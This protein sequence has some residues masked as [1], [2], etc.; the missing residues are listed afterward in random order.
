MGYERVGKT[1]LCKALRG[2]AV[3]AAEPSTDGVAV[4][5][6]TFALPSQPAPRAVLRVSVWDFAGQRVYYLTHQFFLS[7]RATYLLLWKWA[8]DRGD[9]PSQ[10]ERQLFFWLRSIEAQAPS[11]TVFV[12]GTHCRGC[13]AEEQALMEEARRRLETAF[14]GLQLRFHLVDSCA[15]VGVAALRTALLEQAESA[16]IA[17]LPAQWLELRDRV[18]ADAA[19]DVPLVSLADFQ[20]EIADFPKVQEALKFWHDL[21]SLL[22]FGE[23]EQLRK[24]VVLQPQWLADA[25]RCV[26]TQ[27]EMTRRI[28]DCGGRVRRSQVLEMFSAVTSSD[29]FRFLLVELLVQFQIVHSVGT[30]II[31]PYLLPQPAASERSHPMMVGGDA[32]ARR[33]DVRLQFVPRGLI[34]RVLCGVLKLEQTAWTQIKHLCAVGADVCRTSDSSDVCVKLQLVH[35]AG[36]GGGDCE[37]ASCAPGCI[38]L[39]ASGHPYQERDALL[40]EVL[41]IICEMVVT[42][43]PGLVRLAGED[44]FPVDLAASAAETRADDRSRFGF[45]EDHPSRLLVV[46]SLRGEIP[47]ALSLAKLERAYREGRE[48]GDGWPTVAELLRQPRDGDREATAVWLCD[49]D[50]RFSEDVIPAA[51]AA[52]A[53]TQWCAGDSKGGYFDIPLEVCQKLEAAFLAKEEH[54]EAQAG[55]WA[56]VFDLQKMVQ[57]NTTTGK[58]RPLLR[59]SKDTVVEMML[60]KERDYKQLLEHAATQ[61]AQQVRV[62]KAEAER[63]NQQLNDTQTAAARHIAEV[64]VAEAKRR[65]ADAEAAQKVADERVRQVKAE[66]EAKRT[67]EVAEARAKAVHEVSAA[68]QDVK[69]ANQQLKDAQTAAARQIAEVKVAE[70]KRRKADAEAAQKVAD[71]RVRQVREEAVAALQAP[72]AVTRTSLAPSCGAWTSIQARVQESLPQ[73]VVTAVEEIENT[74][75]LLDFDRQKD[76]VAGKPLNAARGGTTENRA[77][78]RLAFHAMAG[79]PDELKKIYEGGRAHGGFDFRLARGG[80]YGRGAYFAEHA[81]YS[82]YLFPRPTKAADGSVVLLVAEVILGQSKDMGRLCGNDRCPGIGAA[83]QPIGSEVIGALVRDPPIEGAAAETYD[84]VQGTESSFGI[85]AGRCFAKNQ[86]RADA[87]RYGGNAAGCEEYGRQYIVYSKAKAYPRYLV[88]IRPAA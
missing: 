68:K 21:G 2:E 59:M 26:I 27:H 54:F 87:K 3:D 30:E 18:A 35:D 4:H 72:L 51:A 58:E 79:G 8:P 82:A 53:P 81:I 31:F 40:R 44:D 78:V 46:P 76:I 37:A 24:F 28:R 60:R 12:V 48:L 56:Y 71:E 75:L 33:V 64:K 22:W 45:G 47:A 70:A 52:A 34:G 86:M 36:A 11:A 23:Y 77:N 63:A 10:Q 84:S 88:T 29:R 61:S 57:R 39:R 6:A 14:P 20:T 73:H 65:E 41:R 25:F 42:S 19:R 1:T 38:Q 43:F 83:C 80:A 9:G 15:G 69:R 7:P 13:S 17:R 55:R 62:A 85:H 32:S 74:E 16:P 67:K 49:N 66:E 50:H 5:E